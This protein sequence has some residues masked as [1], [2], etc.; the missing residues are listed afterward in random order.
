M[1]Q[2]GRTG[3]GQP[4]GRS[5]PEARVHRKELTSHNSSSSGC[6]EMTVLADA[7]FE[8]VAA[9]AARDE[10]GDEDVRVEEEPHETRE[11]TS[12]SVKM[13]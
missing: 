4:D 1:P 9:R 10:G 13:P 12:S 7:V 6:D 8:Q 3:I 5:P 11:N 2:S